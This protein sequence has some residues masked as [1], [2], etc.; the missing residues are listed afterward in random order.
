[1]ILWGGNFLNNGVKALSEELK[2]ASDIK[3]LIGKNKGEED[4]ILVAQRFLNIFRQLHIFDNQRREEFNK[5]ILDLPPESRGMF[6][7][8]PG[9]SIL[10]EYVDELEINSGAIRSATRTTPAV[11][12]DAKSPLS[13][14]KSSIVGGKTNDAP[15]FMPMGDA[16]IIADDNF[17]KALAEALRG[18]REAK[19]I[20]MQD[21][22]SAVKEGSKAS[23]GGSV[24]VDEK[25]AKAMA[26]AFA[27]AL[28]F[29]DANKKADIGELIDAIRESKNIVWPDGFDSLSDDFAK[30]LS[31]SLNEVLKASNASRNDEIKQL[32]NA[33]KETRSS[34]PA[35]NIS[36]DPS[37][38]NLSSKVVIDDAFAETLSKSLAQAFGEKANESSNDIK[39][40]VEA[41]KTNKGMDYDALSQALIKGLRP[42]LPNEPATLSYVPLESDLAP[43]N[44]EQT[45]KKA[46]ESENIRFTADDNFAEVVS[47]AVAKTIEATEQS[48]L[49]QTKILMNG[50]QDLIKN[51]P[52]MEGNPAVI[53][54]ISG[55][56]DLI[57]KITKEFTAAINELTEARKSENREIAQAIN[58]INQTLTTKEFNVPAQ[59]EN[60]VEDIVT[61]ITAAQSSALQEISQKQA[62]DLMMI[63]SSTLKETQKSSVETIVEALKSINFSP[64]I[65]QPQI[66][67]T[68][69][70]VLADTDLDSDD[71]DDFDEDLSDVPTTSFDSMLEKK[72]KKKKKKKK[73][74]EKFEPI[75]K[76]TDY[77]AKINPLQNDVIKKKSE[78][79]SY[80]KS[81]FESAPIE[82]PTV[83]K[84][85]WGFGDDSGTDD[86]WK[87]DVDEASEWGLSEIAPVEET[88]FV[89]DTSYADTSEGVE[90]QDWEW[91]YEEETEEYSAASDNGVEGQDWEWEYEEEAEDLAGQD[92]QETELFASDDEFI[93]DDQD[94][95]AAISLNPGVGILA[96]D[97]ADDGLDLGGESQIAISELRQNGDNNDPYLTNGNIGV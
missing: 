84:S 66:Q 9:G 96:D 71:E 20:E 78:V 81:T 67:V 1:M 63:I 75:E 47:S 27:Q 95:S 40:L 88:S 46:P 83:S 5:L 65:Q 10:Q 79:K 55:N 91:E 12:T 64:I 82:E 54:S 25:F 87:D 93:A 14:I 73:S 35:S 59:A 11:S 19:R 21:L 8:L 38:L 28:Q 45:P 50:F 22:I 37:N 57:E 41:L 74:D 51:R 92:Q 61:A 17:G 43:N 44:D 52:I 23:V 32:V 89:E 3:K 36:V 18:D 97:N 13:Q 86:L 2:E 77:S 69:P 30:A 16:K 24:M 94:Q 80:I 34:E 70:N 7:A 85:D 58:A 29:S 90:G 48:R 49:E 53:S 56:E 42:L 26:Q 62:T 31:K 39:E 6:G 4:P 15:T 60:N 68:A 33:I 72:K 76:K